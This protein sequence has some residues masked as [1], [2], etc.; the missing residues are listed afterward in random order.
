MRSVN[1]YRTDQ[2]DFSWSLGFQC[3]LY[4]FLFYVNGEI[5]IHLIL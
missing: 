3:E 2:I 1:F 5:Q 4:L